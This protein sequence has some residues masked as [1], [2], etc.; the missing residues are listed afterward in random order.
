MSADQT[1]VTGLSRDSECL[2]QGDT[3]QGARRA[4]GD[5]SHLQEEVTG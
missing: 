2:H 3:D 1:R 5:H 4:G